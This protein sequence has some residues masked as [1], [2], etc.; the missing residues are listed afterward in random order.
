ML[1]KYSPTDCPYL[2]E[3][4]LIRPYLGTFFFFFF[5]ILNNYYLKEKKDSLC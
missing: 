5:S 1:K 4:P 3:E 2:V